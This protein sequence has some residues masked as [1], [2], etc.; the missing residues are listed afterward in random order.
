MS[1]R[2]SP[3]FPTPFTAAQMRRAG[4]GEALVHY[5]SQPGATAVVCDRASVVPHL[6]PTGADDFERLVDGLLDASIPPE[7]WQRCAL[8]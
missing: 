3:T 6:I 5:L 4:S 1:L 8:I 7:I 2:Q